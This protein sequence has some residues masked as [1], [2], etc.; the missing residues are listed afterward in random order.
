MNFTKSP[1]FKEVYKEK[2][3]R[4]NLILKVRNIGE[5]LKISNPIKKELEFLTLCLNN[6]MIP[7]L[8]TK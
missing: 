1:A 5:K 2:I 4:F 7:K 3:F 8:I 6:T